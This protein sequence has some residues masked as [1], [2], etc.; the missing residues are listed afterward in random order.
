MKRYEGLPKAGG[1]V[2]GQENEGGA[3]YCW[4]SLERLVLA[5]VA[6]ENVSVLN[7]TR[8]EL[9]KNRATINWFIS[10]L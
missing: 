1:T 10:N 5:Q 8:L 4:K 6:G 2:T 7:V 3:P 9:T